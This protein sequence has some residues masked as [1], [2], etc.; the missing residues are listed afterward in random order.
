MKPRNSPGR[1]A[2]ATVLE[3]QR[4]NTAQSEAVRSL[5]VARREADAPRMHRAEQAVIVEYLPL[6]SALARRY[7]RSGIDADDLR[8]VASVG[9]IK[10]IRAW[11]PE[12]GPLIGYVLP[13]VRGEIRRYFRDNGATIRIPRSLYEGQ[14]SVAAA[15]R[16][17][18]QELSR[19]PSIA[20][21][22]EA[23]QLPDDRVRQIEAA[24]VACHP[25]SS[26]ANE[27]WLA[28]LTSY[29]AQS[30]LSTADIRALLRPAMA[31]LSARERR[32][33]ALRFVWGH[34]QLQIATALGLSQ[35]HISRLLAA[36]L[37]KLRRALEPA[38]PIAIGAA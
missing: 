10:A 23:A 4:R 32:I 17:L 6:A 3:T 16:A 34:S 20:E 14:P 15:R 37:R 35:M 28:S 19:E 24:A 36:S 13:T 11:Q 33:I 2:R 27:D 26:D 12:K 30:D 31:T 9:L 1:A 7:R 25:A 29:A 21:V 18:R 22:A 38:R 8:Q 5:V